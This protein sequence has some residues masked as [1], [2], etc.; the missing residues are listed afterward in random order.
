M[1]YKVE[2]FKRITERVYKTSDGPKYFQSKFMDKYIYLTCA[3]FKSARCKATSK[4]NR[5]SN[6]IFL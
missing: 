6:S 3:L 2:E 1:E 5:E 4:L